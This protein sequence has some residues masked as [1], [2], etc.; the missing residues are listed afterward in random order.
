MIVIKL[1]LHSAI[2]GKVTEIGRTIIANTGS[3]DDI[4]RSDYTVYVSR[5]GK[6]FSN[7]RTLRSP[8]RKGSV[9]DYPRLTYNVWRLVTRG[10]L[11]AFP[12]EQR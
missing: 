6:E 2:T 7:K 10:L 1:E 4:T 5:R 3:C 9:E 11:S 8:L 12:E